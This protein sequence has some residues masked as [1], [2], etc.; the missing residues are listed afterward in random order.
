VSEVKAG[1]IG[2]CFYDITAIKAMVSRL[3]K[4]SG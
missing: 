3:I 2:F 4:Q 1:V